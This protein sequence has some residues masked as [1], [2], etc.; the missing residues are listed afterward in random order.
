MHRSATSL[1][2]ELEVYCKAMKAAGL[3]NNSS[4]LVIRGI[5]D[6]ADS[7][8]NQGWQGYTAAVAAAYAK[9]LL[10]VVPV[11]LID[12]VPAAPSPCG[13]SRARVP[14]DLNTTL[15]IEGFVGRQAEL[16]RLWFHLQLGDSPTRKVAILHGLGGIGKTH[17]AV[18][19]ARDHKN[20]FVATI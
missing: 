6:Y 9:G 14:L 11:H 3:M 1:A 15:A 8:K 20:D 10:L 16:D 18:H 17:L 13:A 4:C 12:E 2:K 19:F 7:H 5:C